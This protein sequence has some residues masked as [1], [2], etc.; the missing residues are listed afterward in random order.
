MK[1][2]RR[3]GDRADGRRIRTL[4]PMNRISPY[5]MKHRQDASNLIKDSIDLEKVDAYILRKRKEGLTG[6]GILHVLLGAYV[7]TV[8]QRPYINRFISGQ[9]IYA[10]NEISIMMAVKKKMAVDGQETCVKLIC[11]PTDTPEI[12]YHKFNKILEEN[13]TEVE[14]DGF[15][16]LARLVNLLPGFVLRWFVGIIRLMDYGGFAPKKILELSPFH[17]SMFITSMGS[18]GIPP[19]YHHLYDFGNVPVFLAYGKKRREF[20]MNEEGKIVERKYVDFTVTTDE[21]ICDGFTYATTLKMLHNY[22]NNPDLL[23]T[24]P[25]TVVEDID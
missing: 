12:I 15:D 3:F 19:I 14:N 17:G 5:I 22:C 13:K 18:L 24:P 25:E 2:K 11:D 21:R 9:K 4:D 23:D 16:R 20:E 6:F 10:R 1:R 8:S 7:R